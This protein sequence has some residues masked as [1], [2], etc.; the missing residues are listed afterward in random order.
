MKI[1]TDGGITLYGEFEFRGKINESELR[2][3]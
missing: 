3:S 2:T 1:S